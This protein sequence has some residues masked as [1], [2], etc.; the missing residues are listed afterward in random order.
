MRSNVM[1]AGQ[2]RRQVGYCASAHDRFRTRSGCE[3]CG[4][5]GGTSANCRGRYGD[6]EVT[7]AGEG[8]GA[9]SNRWIKVERATGLRLSHKREM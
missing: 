7:E 8:E 4:C 5:V 1:I 3:S 2:E 6:G 9:E